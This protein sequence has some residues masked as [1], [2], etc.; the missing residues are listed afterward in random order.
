MTEQVDLSGIESRGDL[1]IDEIPME[2]YEMYVPP[3]PPEEL[4]SGVEK[5]RKIL[6]I[7]MWLNEFQES[8]KLKR[9]E[10]FNLENLSMLELE[11]MLEEM[12]FVIGVKN[13]IGNVGA[14]VTHSIQGLEVA[15]CTFTP[16]KAKGLAA[17]TTT[18]A[19]IDD[20]KHMCLKRISMLNTS[21]EMRI[22]FTL[23]TAILQLHL[24]NTKMEELRSPS[25]PH[26]KPIISATKTVALENLGAAF[27][28]L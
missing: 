20:V 7:Q 2:N 3:P 24:Q 10:K 11:R 14:L 1:L 9:Y 21:P 15:L 22:A 13:N 23:T 16:I 17:A 4:V 6:T 26:Q 18:P 8:G 12:D 5:R 27:G 19:M 25:E 28:D